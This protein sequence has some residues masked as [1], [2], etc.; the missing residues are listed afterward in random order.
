MRRPYMS[1]SRD[2]VNS[3]HNADE[4]VEADAVAGLKAVADRLAADAG[5]AH[6]AV[7]LV[8]EPV[9]DVVGQ[10]AVNADRLQAVQHGVA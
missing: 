10:L 8:G 6:L 4:K 1:M 9:V 7:G 3:R 2:A 5:D